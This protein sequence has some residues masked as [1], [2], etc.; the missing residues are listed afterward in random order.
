MRTGHQN[1]ATTAPELLAVTLPFAVVG[2]LVAWRQRGNPIG[3]LM[4]SFTLGF[5]ISIDVG[6]YDLAVYRYGRGWP[7]SLS[8]RAG[9]GTTANGSF[10]PAGG[11]LYWVSWITKWRW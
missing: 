2:L 3:W 7:L 5:M 11:P 6:P 9:Y 8:I 10:S 1:P 4:L